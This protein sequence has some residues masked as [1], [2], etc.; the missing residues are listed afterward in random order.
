[1]STIFAPERQLVYEWYTPSL[2]KS[3]AFLQAFGFRVLRRE[4]A[5]AELSYGRNR[6]LVEQM[7]EDYKNSEE[8]SG[9]AVGYRGYHGNLRIL[10]DNVDAVYESS[11]M[12]TNGCR[13]LKEVGDRYY[14]LRDFTV[15]GPYGLALRF[16]QPLPGFTED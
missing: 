5:F 13:V 1:M 16:A 10:V 2:E 4:A 7:Q 12:L 6:L 8:E 14:G 9:G 15:G 3:I 11:A